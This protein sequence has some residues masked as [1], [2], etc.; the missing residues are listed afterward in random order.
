M[1]TLKSIIK[2]NIDKHQTAL[3]KW[4]QRED[5]EVGTEV[6]IW[7]NINGDTVGRKFVVGDFEVNAYGVFVKEKV[8]ET[9]TVL[10]H[11]L[12][13]FPYIKGE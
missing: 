1:K 12:N 2:E 9:D 3:E 5:I 13:V 10:I 11:I 7:E 6:Y 4:K 8:N